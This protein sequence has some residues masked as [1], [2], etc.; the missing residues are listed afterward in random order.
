MYKQ[1]IEENNPRAQVMLKPN[2]GKTSFL[3]NALNSGEI[4]IYPEFTG[5][6]LESLVKVPAEQQNRRLSP[7]QTYQTAKDLLT[8]QQRLTFLPPMAYQNTYALAVSQDYAAAHNLHKISDLKRVQNQIRAGFTLDLPTAP[9]AT[10]VCNN[11]AYSLTTSR[12]SNP[13]CATPPS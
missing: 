7:E 10:K 12:R 8:R 9:T 11:T 6:V 4:D 1:L 2:F 5:T 13:P 3:F